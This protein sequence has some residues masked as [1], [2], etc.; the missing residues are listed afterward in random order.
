MASKILLPSTGQPIL[1]TTSGYFAHLTDQN[2]ASPNGLD[3][4]RFRCTVLDYKIELLPYPPVAQGTERLPKWHP[5][6]LLPYALL[7]NFVDTD[8]TAH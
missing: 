4:S 6:N 1:D 5:T 7:H 8:A 2:I 3:F